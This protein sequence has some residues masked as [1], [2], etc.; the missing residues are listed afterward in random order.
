MPHC[1]SCMAVKH[2]L[3]TRGIAYRSVNV[4]EDKGAMARLASLG[5]RS[6]PVVVRNGRFVFAQYLPDVSVFLG[7]DKGRSAAL[8][9]M[10]LA[11]RLVQFLEIALEVLAKTPER[12]F[13]RNLPGRDRS[14]FVVVH[15]V[16]Q[17]AAAARRGLGDGRL[18]DRDSLAEP[19]ASMT[20]RETLMHFSQGVIADI[21]N[22]PIQ[23]AAAGKD[24]GIVTDYGER[25]LDEV[26]HRVVSHAAQHTRQL[27]AWARMSGVQLQQEPTPALLAG[28]TVADDS[29]DQT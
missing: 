17:I 28:L 25:P 5:A 13:E 2:F 29:F 1:S 10:E 19:P 6:V 16:F 15:H 27:A 7:L 20:T 4:L 26:L 11:S 18:L 21:R 8:D 14:Y 23:L 24:D 3:D 12:E 22:W 9:R